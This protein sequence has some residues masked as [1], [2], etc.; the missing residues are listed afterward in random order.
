MDKDEPAKS[1]VLTHV[2]A[3]WW[4]RSVHPQ[5]TADT[6]RTS[7][8]SLGSG[9]ATATE[10]KTAKVYELRQSM[11]KPGIPKELPIELLSGAPITGIGPRLTKTR[12]WMGLVPIGAICAQD[13]IYICSP[14]FCFVL[15]ASDIKH[16]CKEPVKRWQQ[17]VILAV[18]GCELCGT[19]SRQDTAR[20]FRDRSVQL[21]NVWQLTTFVGLMTSERGGTLSHDAMR[22]V[23]DGLN[24]PMETVLYL[25]LCLPPAWGGLGL[26][27]PRSNWFLDVPDHL[28]RGKRQAR[29]VPDMLWPEF[30]LIAEYFGKDAHIG[31]EVPD[32]ERQEL[33]QD[34][35]Y[36]V[37][38]FWKEDVSDL[39]RFN[40]KA[41]S[42]ASHMGRKLPKPTEDFCKQQRT[43]LQMLMKHQPWI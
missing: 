36:S 16:I 3:I 39:R 42:L 17:V 43:L 21:V 15:I 19:Y 40:A 22:W 11:L 37:I 4:W 38:T 13:G 24:S 32:V 41:R 30:S 28:Q 20:G 5:T 23:I 29:I 10:M 25:M 33:A 14:E 31:H 8:C 18:L 27:R 2:W 12:R 34:M 7:I 35:G 6:F 1:I 26:P 9:P